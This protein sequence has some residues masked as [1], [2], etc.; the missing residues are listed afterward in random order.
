MG[1]MWNRHSVVSRR[2]R[3]RADRAERIY[4]LLVRLYPAAHRRTWESEMRQTFRDHA[5]DVLEA[6]DQSS[7]GF[8]LA[9]VR[10]EGKSLAREYMAAAREAIHAAIAAGKDRVETTMRIGSKMSMR[11]GRALLTAT[12]L[13]LAVVG[14]GASVALVPRVHAAAVDA[15]AYFGI[16]LPGDDNY[17]R[18]AGPGM[19]PTLHSGENLQVVPYGRGSG[20]HRGDIVAFRLPTY[21]NFAYVKRVVAVPG[22]TVE[23]TATA[24]LINGRALPSPLFGNKV[25]P[26]ETLGLGEYFVLGDNAGNSLDSR[27]FG[28]IPSSALLGKIT[29]VT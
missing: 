3:T 2:G 17:I 13:L 8:W 27:T 7:T 9:V 25:A 22:D 23:V 21:P 29:P 16:T 4:A 26:K 11:L 20:P 5:R 18:M 19:Q 1:C 12:L 28:P 14:M 15:T 10:D 6:H 24:V